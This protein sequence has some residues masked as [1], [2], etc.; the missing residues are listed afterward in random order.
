M[1][2]DVAPAGGFGGPGSYAGLRRLLPVLMVLQA[3]V[4]AYVVWATIIRA[5]FEDMLSWLDAYRRSG[6]SADYYFG[7]FQ[8]HHL[9]WAKLLTA[10]DASLFHGDGWVF[11]VVGLLSLGG[12]A[13][14]LSWEFRRGLPS[15]GPI[16]SLVWL[17]PMLVLTVANAV[18][19]SVPVNIVYPL[20]LLFVVGACVMMD[21]PAEAGPLPPWRG[22][23]AV[24]LAAGAGFA[25]AVGLLAWPVLVWSAWRCRVGWRWVAAIA[26]IG[27]VYGVAYLRGVTLPA[28]GAGV[29]VT[30]VERFVKEIAYLLAYLGLPLSRVPALRLAGEALGAVLLAAAVLAFLRFGVMRPAI[31]RLERIATG[32]ILFSFGTAVLAA[33][34]RSQFSAGIE[35]P[36]RY[37]VLVTP[38]HVG[39]LALGLRWVADHPGVERRAGRVLAGGVALALVLVAQ[40]VVGARS[41]VAVADVMRGRID[42]FYAGAHDPDIERLVY[43]AG[44]DKADAIVEGL[45]RDGLLA[46]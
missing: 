9:V 19:C 14:L 20:T 11:I 18:D 33:L 3:V 16:A 43:Q 1:S 44:L 5:P 30:G 40:Q 46:R 26:A 27:L 12:V 21:G 13:G 36:V 45:R 42:R 10:V 41:A 23:L 32:L 24:A 35:L 17:C 22:A 4:F 37:S 31:T 29:S 28:D 7:F 38:L 34:G 2:I 15:G 8:E 6:G 39:L 25:N